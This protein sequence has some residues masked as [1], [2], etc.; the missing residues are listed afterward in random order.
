MGCSDKDVVQAL[1]YCKTPDIEQLFHD[2]WSSLDWPCITAVTDVC[3]DDLLFEIEA[4]AA[5]QQ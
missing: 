3:R 4:T 5:V 2:K 1:V